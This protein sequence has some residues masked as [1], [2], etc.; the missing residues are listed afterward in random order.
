MRKYKLL[1]KSD[2]SFFEAA[3]SSERWPKCG[4]GANGAEESIGKHLSERVI[5]K[6]IF[7]IKKFTRR[8]PQPFPASG[9][10][11][12]IVWLNFAPLLLTFC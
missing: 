12:H 4:S 10:R 5:G 11:T 1:T 2:K 8:G 6:F 7:A 9:P 3:S